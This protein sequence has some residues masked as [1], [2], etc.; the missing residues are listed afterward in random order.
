ME[1][2]ARKTVSND[3][4]LPDTSSFAAAFTQ[5]KQSGSTDTTQRDDFYLFD[6]RRMQSKCF[7]D[8]DTVG[9]LTDG[10]RGIHIAALALQHNP[11]KHLHTF[12]VPFDDSDMNLD[13][14]TGPECRN[15][16]TH[17]LSINLV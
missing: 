4:A 14:I 2:R 3:A 11:L 13:G 12:F 17:L 7:F 10:E 5:I 15:I 6:T 1:G 8:P 9:D 16:K